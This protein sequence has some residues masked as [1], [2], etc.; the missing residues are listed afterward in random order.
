MHLEAVAGG[1]GGV[2]LLLDLFAFLFHHVSC[3]GRHC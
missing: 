1:G 2:C 3:Y